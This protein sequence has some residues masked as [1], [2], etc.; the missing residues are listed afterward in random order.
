MQDNALARLTELEDI[1]AIRQL[2]YRYCQACDDDHNPERLGPLF[3]EDAVWE[4]SSMGRYE[5]RTAI[6]AALGALGKSGRIRNSA[7]NA[8]NPIIQVEGDLARGEWR[9]IMLYTGVHPNG[10]LHFSRIIGWY[11]ETYAKLDGRWHITSL[12]C[13]VE[14]SAPYQLAP[15]QAV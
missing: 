8:I 2:K 10:E 9:L 1:E 13:Q 4:A 11:K 6:Q 12:Y 15:E 3:S 7:H 14:E 5:G